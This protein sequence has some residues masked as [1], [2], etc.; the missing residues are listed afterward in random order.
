LLIELFGWRLRRG[1]YVENNNTITLTQGFEYDSSTWQV[2]NP[3]H[4]VQSSGDYSFFIQ[5]G[6]LRIIRGVYLLKLDQKWGDLLMWALILCNTI[7]GDQNLID[8]ALS[9]GFVHRHSIRKF[10]TTTY[11]SPFC[12]AVS[13]IRNCADHSRLG[14]NNTEVIE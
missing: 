7:C 9:F 3:P 6:A 11:I 10:Q 2:C 4:Q 1:A 12:A 13:E 14:T 5:A 8:G